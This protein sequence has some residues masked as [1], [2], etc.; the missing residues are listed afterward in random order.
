MKKGVVFLVTCT[1]VGHQSPMGFIVIEHLTLYKILSTDRNSINVYGQ[2]KGGVLLEVWSY[3]F[4][5]PVRE[6][7]H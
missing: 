1:D 4:V 6:E 3:F 5:I 2:M 7:L